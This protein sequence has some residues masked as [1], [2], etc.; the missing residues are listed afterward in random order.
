MVV[1]K[2]FQQ[3]RITWP[4]EILRVKDVLTVTYVPLDVELQHTT[5]GFANPR[6]AIGVQNEGCNFVKKIHPLAVH[7]IQNMVLFNEQKKIG[8][9]E[10]HRADSLESTSKS[11]AKIVI[12]AIQYVGIFCIKSL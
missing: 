11:S 10:E 4:P 1:A 7:V 9:R 12:T 5:M 2:D 6:K 3:Q 8:R